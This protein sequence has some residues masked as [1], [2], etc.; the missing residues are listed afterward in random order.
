MIMSTLLV[1]STLIYGGLSLQPNSP[2]AY[3]EPISRSFKISVDAQAS[4]DGKPNQ[5]VKVEVTGKSTVDGKTI[6]IDQS[7]LKGKL[8][9]A[10]VG[11]SLQLTGLSVQVDNKLKEL[12][13]KGTVKDSNGK[14]LG[15]FEM[16]LN[17]SSTID[18]C[19]DK[20]I[21]TNRTFVTFK[22]ATGKKVQVNSKSIVGSIE[23]QDDTPPPAPNDPPVAKL[24]ANPT[25]IDEGQ[26]SALDASGS[27]DPNGDKLTYSFTLLNN[28]PGSITD[29]NG[30]TAKY[31]APPDVDSDQTITIQVKVDDGKG[32][33]ATSEASILVKNIPP[34]PPPN[35]NPIADAGNDFA[36]DEGTAAVQLK[37]DGSSD[38]DGNIASY[39]W[40]QIV[41]GNEPAVTLVDGDKATASFTAPQVS[42]QTQ[43]TFKLTVT[44][45][46]GAVDDD[47]VVVTVNDIVSNPPP[48]G[49]TTVGPDGGTVKSSD[50]SVELT[51]PPGALDK[52]VQI[53]IEQKTSGFPNGA[54][55]NV[56]D[57]GPNGL[58]FSQPA[59]LTLKYDEA[60][61]PS[62]I[63]E[64]F[65]GVGVVIDE[66]RGPEWTKAALSDTVDSDKNTVTASIS[67]LSIFG[68]ISKKFDL[69]FLGKETHILNG[70]T[71][72]STSYSGN[73]E[74]STIFP[75]DWDGRGVWSVSCF[76]KDASGNP[77]YAIDNM[78]FDT[79]GPAPFVLASLTQNSNAG[80]G[81]T[82]GGQSTLRF[83][84]SPDGERQDA[85][86]ITWKTWEMNQVLGSNSLVA[87]NEIV[88]D[89][90]GNLIYQQ[91]WSARAFY[92]R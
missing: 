39:K 12:T 56:Y 78:G 88:R 31:N 89:T 11:T 92:G 63:T 48:G 19:A 10:G 54:L 22:F 37:G 67:H 5:A 46:K 72:L 13:V 15:T 83:P 35:Q 82:L 64:G 27:S 53:T 84:D 9:I 52:T 81:A 38:Q 24:I 29:Q 25:T 80:G 47:T 23:C 43:L 2:T 40:E 45:D 66:G 51:I 30:A 44:D 20:T 32:R 90:D 28:G 8:S 65:V 91:Q 41:T 77:T 16:R 73:L 60:A 69:I 87:F 68:P 58:Q 14:T 26:S 42:S 4:V 21:T 18:L 6:K 33:T 1:S 55:G 75:G 86:P 3:A 36:V 34:P 85:C 59:R 17:F 70:V 49:G 79:T 7:S 50:G 74:R 61:L 62:D 71:I 76:T 57:I